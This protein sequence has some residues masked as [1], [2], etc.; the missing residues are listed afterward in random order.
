MPRNWSR[1]K[2]RAG[3]AAQQ[4]D[5]CLLDF[6][7]GPCLARGPHFHSITAENKEKNQMARGRRASEV[8]LVA[9][10]KLPTRVLG[11]GPARVVNSM[12]VNGNSGKAV[13]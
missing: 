8:Q 3:E 12:F 9:T 5:C 6:R 13:S 2:N 4:A 1:D 11:Q 7:H 10:H